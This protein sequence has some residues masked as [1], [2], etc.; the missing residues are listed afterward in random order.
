M[1]ELTLF[2]WDD[3]YDSWY[4]RETKNFG[5]CEDQNITVNKLGTISSASQ[6]TITNIVGGRNHSTTIS[7]IKKLC[8][9]LEISIIDF[10]DADLFR[11]RV[12]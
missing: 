9:G 2:G 6:S 4:G 12:S 8:D 11:K 5:L 10:F 1:L 3:R 7:T